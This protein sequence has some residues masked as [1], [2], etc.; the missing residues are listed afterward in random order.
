MS[1]YSIYELKCPECGVQ[2]TQMISDKEENLLVPCPACDT[3]LEKVRKL[4]GAE[5]L[6]CGIRFGGG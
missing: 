2:Y 3:D 5:S 4:T 1:R 6:S